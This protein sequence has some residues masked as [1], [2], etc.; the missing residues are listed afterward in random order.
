MCVISW[1][2]DEMGPRLP[3]DWQPLPIQPGVSPGISLGWLTTPPLDASAIE[4]LRK[5]IDRVAG[6]CTDFRTAVEAAK[7]LDVIFQ[8]PDCIDPEKAKL[9]TRVAELEDQVAKY[10][11][12]IQELL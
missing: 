2:H 10:R 11:R 3:Q 6:I 9:Q 7:K 1:V 12:I 4:T 8:Q 5:E